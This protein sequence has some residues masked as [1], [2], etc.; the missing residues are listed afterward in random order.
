[1]ILY[2]TC[3]ENDEP[4]NYDGGKVLLIAC[5]GQRPEI[6]GQL[7][8]A[9]LMLMCVYDEFMRQ[10]P[11]SRE[12]KQEVAF[13]ITIDEIPVAELPPDPDA[14]LDLFN[15]RGEQVDAAGNLVPNGRRIAVAGG[16]DPAT[17]DPR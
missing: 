2:M 3:V 1:M 17:G 16:P 5:R 10:F 11:V 13:R 12:A 8:D 15:G 14:P 4:N 9:R 6:L 7:T